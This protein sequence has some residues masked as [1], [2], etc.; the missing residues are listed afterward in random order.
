MTKE[1]TKAFAEVDD[2]IEHLD[3][4]EKSKI[5]VNFIN[6]IKEKKDTEYK[7]NID[8]TQSIVNQKLLPSTRKLLTLIYRDCLCSDSEKKDLIKNNE[9]LLKE[10][11]EKYEVFKEQPVN[12][13]ETNK[14]QDIVKNEEIKAI[15]VQEKSFFKKIINKI[16][17]FIHQK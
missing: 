6:L 13:N 7:V 5:S 10:Q 2:I 14:K 9:K 1:L 3:N 16:L 4:S 11:K 17:R 15:A 12:I 8:Y